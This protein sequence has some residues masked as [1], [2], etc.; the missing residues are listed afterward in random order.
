MS[1]RRTY[2]ALF[3]VTVVLAGANIGYFSWIAHTSPS[4]VAKQYP[5]VSTDEELEFATLAINMV[6]HHAFSLSTT[7][8]YLATAWRPPGYPAFIAPFY[9]VFHSF[10]PVLYVQVLLL[11]LT[12]LLIYAIARR[13]IGDR[14]AFWL[15]IL[16][17]CL[18]DTLLSASTL[19][20]ENL[21]M[22]VFMAALYIFLS[23]KVQ[24]LYAKWALTGFL[25]ALATYVRVP[26]LYLL[27]FFIPA[28][29][30]F[31]LPWKDFSKRYVLAALCMIIAFAATLAPWCI[32]N[33]MHFGDSSFTSASAFELFKQNAGR[34]Y[35]GI[36]GSTHDET[37]ATL[38]AK[39]GI[40]VG[41]VPTDLTYAPAMKR[42]ALEVIFSHPYRY[43]FFQAS[44]MVP[45]FFSPGAHDYWRFV[46]D[47]MPD[48]NPP[49]EPSFVQ[50]LNP[51]SI[52]LLITVFENHG[53]F[54]LENFF[55]LGVFLLVLLGLWK[56]RDTRQARFFFAIMIYF[57]LITGPVAHARYRI[58]VEPLLLLGA[59]SAAVYWLDERR[60]TQA[61][62]P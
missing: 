55:W 59:F 2:L 50:A 20:S 23:P 9:A 19:L 47:M 58:P 46:M 61:A 3:I 44:A 6:D 30:L 34:F 35:E 25:L 5:A 40:P 17:L 12:V 32:R 29:F 10:Y 52:P 53:W 31:Y 33:E 16:Y 11:Y 24:N 8:P 4:P 18:P 14:P 36:S 27:A 13:V 60:R 48:F 26:S 41:D 62:I 45:F 37:I 49:P 7:S 22:L 15:C 39:A 42:V 1:D 54:L 57:A 21:F 43:A 51:L 38:E 28:Y 56:S